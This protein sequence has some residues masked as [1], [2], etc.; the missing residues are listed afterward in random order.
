MSDLVLRRLAAFLYSS[1][2]RSS[3]IV[4]SLPSE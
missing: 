3:S 1:T 4:S 2:A